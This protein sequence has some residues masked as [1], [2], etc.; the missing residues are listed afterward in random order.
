MASEK[1]KRTMCK[2]RPETK[3]ETSWAL[4][5]MRRIVTIWETGLTQID[6]EYILRRIRDKDAYVF[7]KVAAER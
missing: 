2:Y 7:N 3:Q 1:G 5:R 4:S 6:K